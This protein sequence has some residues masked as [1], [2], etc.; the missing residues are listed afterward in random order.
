M[1]TPSSTFSRFPILNRLEPLIR[2]MAPGQ[3]IR[4][5]IVGVWNTGFGYALY[6]GFV[7]LLDPI[8]H[9]PRSYLLA[10]ILSNIIA[11]SGAFLGY[12]WFVFKTKGN[13][14]REW[15]RCFLVY[16]SSM[17]IGLLLLP[18]LVQLVRA[19]IH[20]ER[21]APYIAGAALTGLSVIYSFFGHRKYSFR[22][23]Q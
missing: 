3:F 12:K 10:S 7:A 9:Q 4:Y 11:I 2:Q 18:I 21:S 8:L 1:S 20:S 22:R 17:V 16:G 19:V 6:A 14:L 5:L 13:Y 23:S 15:L